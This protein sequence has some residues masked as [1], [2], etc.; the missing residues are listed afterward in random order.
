MKDLIIIGAGPAGLGASI[1]ASRYKIDHL[2]IGREIGG[3]VTG[4]S[5]IENWAGEI[6]ISG[7]ALMDKFKKHAESFG[8]EIVQAEADGIKKIDGGFEVFS[9]SNN[10]KYEAKTILLALGMR[11]R[12]LDIPGEDRLVGKGVSFCATC[13]AAF[14]KGKEVAVVGGG[15]S[16]ATAALHLAEFAGKVS[17]IY[18]SD[19]IRFDPTWSQKM[20]ENPKIEKVCCSKVVEIK[21]G[22]SVEGI[23]YEMDGTQKEIP[24]QGVFIEIGAVPGVELAHEIGVKTDAENYI[25]VGEDQQ[26]NVE[27]IFAA[28]D[29]TTNSNKFRQI[30]TAVAEGAIAAGSVYRKLKLG[31]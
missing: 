23:V 28:G 15:D 21:G 16:A 1:Y 26:T 3:Q 11:A 10:R 4:A 8:T 30:I 14:F 18:P 6:S 7:Q 27:N 22:E 24:V 29:V 17:I 2:V 19:D 25:I 31:K 9:E 5:A 13:D 12:K 20:D